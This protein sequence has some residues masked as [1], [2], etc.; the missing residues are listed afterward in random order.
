MFGDY[1]LILG[2][3]KNGSAEQPI[4]CICPLFFVLKR[5]VLIKFLV[6][7]INDDSII[8]AGPVPDQ[9]SMY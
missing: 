2:R 4:I 1:E 7:L 8:E 3:L 5:K 6:F 9:W